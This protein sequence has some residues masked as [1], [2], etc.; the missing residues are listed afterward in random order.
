MKASVRR[1]DPSEIFIIMDSHGIETLE[2]KTYADLM[3]MFEQIIMF[4][5]RW[6]DTKDFFLA[7]LEAFIENHRD[8]VVI[9]PENDISFVERNHRRLIKSKDLMDLIEI[10]ESKDED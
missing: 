10:R 6:L 3:N 9:L 7:L 5:P 1:K 4:S 8:S 2:V